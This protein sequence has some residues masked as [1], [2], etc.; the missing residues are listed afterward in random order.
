MFNKSA[1]PY[2][3]CFHSPKII[4]ERYEFDV[5][6]LVQTPTSMHGSSEGHM[7]YL[8]KRSSTAMQKKKDAAECSCDALYQSAHS[9]V[10]QNDNNDNKLENLYKT[11]AASVD[12]E[13]NGGRVTRA[14]KVVHCIESD[15]TSTDEE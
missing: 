3:I 1:S 10:V 4:V 8:Y 9:L 13:I 15:H 14:K 7:G 11:V 2:L 6:L 5:E 12:A